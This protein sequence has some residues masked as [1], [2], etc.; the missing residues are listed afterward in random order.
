MPLPARFESPAEESLD[1][2]VDP[3]TGES[4]KDD[5]QLTLLVAVVLD[6]KPAAPPAEGEQP[7][8]PD[9]GTAQSAA[10]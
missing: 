1:T 6:P 10:E 4:L 8:A 5:W 2:F 3:I 7:A 9:A